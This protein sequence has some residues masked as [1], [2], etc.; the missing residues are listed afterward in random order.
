MNIGVRSV[1]SAMAVILLGL[2]AA[3]C[4]A[5]GEEVPTVM[6][7]AS[8]QVD[9]P[10]MEYL[11]SDEEMELMIL[12]AFKLQSECAARFGLE[13]PPDR[14]GEEDVSDYFNLRRRYGLLNREEVVRYGYDSPPLP[15]DSDDEAHPDLSEEVMTGRTATGDASTMKDSEGQLIPPGGCEQESWDSLRGDIPLGYFTPSLGLLEEARI[16]MQEDPGYK[17]A[18]AD[19]ADCMTAAGHDFRQLH[20]AGA[21][22]KAA[23]PEEKK[24]M[25]LQELEC[26]L[27]VNFPGRA[28]TVDVEIQNELV[29]RNGELLAGVLDQHRR[30]LEKAGEALN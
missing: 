4:S 16:R 29:A 23:P 17:A 9:L 12:A 18:E 3:A 20:E 15:T 2:G 14:P 1:R 5:Q 26:S 21:S 13:L 25:A 28:M 8:S 24:Q 11:P 7:T 10:L 30:M 19:W 27:N 6:V 22:V